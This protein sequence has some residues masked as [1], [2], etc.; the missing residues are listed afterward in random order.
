MINNNA[1]NQQMTI[2][3]HQQ[4]LIFDVAVPGPCGLCPACLVKPP[5]GWR[6]EVD[7]FDGTA[8]LKISAQDSCPHPYVNA[9]DLVSWISPQVSELVNPSW[10]HTAGFA[11]V[12]PWSCPRSTS[13]CPCSHCTCDCPSVLVPPWQNVSSSPG[14]GSQPCRALWAIPVWG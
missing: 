14:L 5:Q 2:N 1:N 3:A 7:L 4:M 11:V 12:L 13:L 9:M 10:C 6:P 8:Q